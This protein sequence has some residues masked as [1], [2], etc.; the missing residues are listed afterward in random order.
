MTKQTKILFLAANPKD[1]TQLKLIEEANKIDAALQA[2]PQRESISLESRWA[3]KAD[4]FRKYLLRY[5]PQFLHFSGHGSKEG[6]IYLE[7]DLGNGQIIRSDFDNNE[8][9]RETHKKATRGLIKES[10]IAKLISL[11]GKNIQCV[12]L[13]ACYTKNLGEA[14][15]KHVE[16]VI[17]MDR[18]I[19]DD[20]AIVFAKTFYEALG[21][22]ENVDVAF[23]LGQVAL[24]NL[25]EGDIPKIHKREESTENPNAKP[26]QVPP[27]DETS[28]KNSV[29]DKGQCLKMVS[30]E[31]ANLLEPPSAEFARRAIAKSISEEFEENADELR[32]NPKGIAKFIINL[33][34][35]SPDDV[36]TI[37]KQIFI[38]AISK[39]AASNELYSGSQRDHRATNE[40]TKEL[41]YLLLGWMV[42]LAVLDE[43]NVSLYK[44]GTFDI[45][46]FNVST[47]VAVEIFLARFL[48]RSAAFVDHSHPKDARGAGGLVVCINEVASEET[49]YAA[50][51]IALDLWNEV[52]PEVKLEK[53]HEL[54]EDELSMLEAIIRHKRGFKETHHYVVSKVGGSFNEVASALCALIPDLVIVGFGKEDNKDKDK[55]KG[56][57]KRSFFAV[58]KDFA[59]AIQIFSKKLE[60]VFPLEVK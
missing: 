22:G 38:P 54:N 29:H 50:N 52:Y 14:I 49:K 24:Q 12:L 18:A 57:D 45:L 43:D 42:H 55:N 60:E 20:A 5:K 36:I 47:K 59:A 3:V 2:T 6:G 26:T 33:H 11:I 32:D 25:G 30:R 1:T 8:M 4:D 10:T 48:G 23:E 46:K 31:I 13:N 19:S 35:D 17:G 15:G 39:L 16:Y 9:T 41:F 7:D 27:K 58:E 34:G 51:K 37:L 21:Y 40:K 28:S 56:K 44:K 53:K